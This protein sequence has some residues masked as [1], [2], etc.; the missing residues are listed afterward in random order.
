MG[1]V[2][3]VFANHL[4]VAQVAK[5]CLGDRWA[6]LS[7]GS[8]HGEDE[9]HTAERNAEIVRSFNAG[10]LDGMICTAVGESSMDVHIQSFCFVCVIDADG[11]VA[12]A[13]QRL[14]R[15]A[16]SER[17]IPVEG[18]STK[19]L[20]SRRLE[21]Q[22]DAVYY[23][24]LTKDTTD[25]ETAKTRQLLFTLEGY[26]QQEEM[27]SEMIMNMAVG[28]GTT[29][30]YNNIVDDV[31]LL[32][33]ILMYGTLGE[34]C[35][36]ASAAAAAYSAPARETIKSR[37]NAATSGSHKLIRDR[38]K[39]SLPALKKEVHKQLKLSKIIKTERIKNQ[40][41]DKQTRDILLSLD[42]DKDVRLQTGISEDAPRDMSDDDDDD[43]DHD[44][45]DDDDD[46]HEDD[47]DE[48]CDDDD[49][50]DEF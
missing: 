36:E 3:I 33:Q 16:R 46:D 22:K 17:V 40:L 14:G 35:T 15:V 28:A 20:V 23:D 5:K 6:V 24:I 37:R 8:A 41:M 1:H 10:E 49:D 48:C 2:G 18:E 21:H 7:G 42:L 50:D 47:D 19:D 9:Q 30:P 32:K 29:L 12:S 31:S 38:A 44:D 11:G 39:S 26:E 34:V 13:A 43:D 4:L 27:Q 45:D 25:F